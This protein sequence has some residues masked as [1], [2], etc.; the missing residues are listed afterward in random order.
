MGAVDVPSRVRAR[1]SVPWNGSKLVPWQTISLSP[2]SS[3]PWGVR[4]AFPLFLVVTGVAVSGVFFVLACTV[5]V[6]VE[7]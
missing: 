4:T 1:I 7:I 5:A 3:L 2:C 6:V